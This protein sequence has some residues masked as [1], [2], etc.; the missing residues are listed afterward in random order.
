[1]EGYKREFIHF[2]E[3]AGVFKFGDFKLVFSIVSKSSKEE[4][5]LHSEEKDELFSSTF[6][7]G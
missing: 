7:S 3:G 2:L 5:E 1:M 6:I 4:D